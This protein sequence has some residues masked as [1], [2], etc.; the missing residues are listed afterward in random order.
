MAIH[1]FSCEFKDHTEPFSY[2]PDVDTELKLAMGSQVFGHSFSAT[3]QNTHFSLPI[4]GHLLK[5][6]DLHELCVLPF[7]WSKECQITLSACQEI[8]FQLLYN[9]LYKY[10]AVFTCV[11]GLHRESMSW[12]FKKKKLGKYNLLHYWV[13]TLANP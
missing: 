8:L 5:F 9:L 7:G 3:R 13:T 4:H 2:Y 12:W 11:W 1:I 10:V 6:Q